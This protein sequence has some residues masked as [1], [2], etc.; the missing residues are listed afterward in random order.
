MKTKAEV[1]ELLKVGKHFCIMPWVH[2]YVSK[3]GYMSPCCQQPV[4]SGALLYGDLSKEQIGD[5]WNGEEIRYL[6]IQM[7]HDKPCDCCKNCYEHEKANVR[8][9]RKLSNSKFADYIDWVLE[10][11]ENGYVESAK[12]VYWDVRFTNKCNLKCRTCSDGWFFGQDLVGMPQKPTGLQN[13]A[14]FLEQLKPYFPTVEELFFSGGEPLLL[15]ENIQI[16]AELDRL[17]KEDTRLIYN[18]NFTKID[19]FLPLWKKF[20]EITFLISIDGTGKRC[21]YLRKGLVWEEIERNMETLKRE[22]PHAHIIADVTVSALN[23]WHLPEMH[24]ELVEKGY[25]QVD[26]FHLNILN[27]PDFYNIRILPEEFKIAVKEKIKEHMKWVKKQEPF[28]NGTDIIHQIQCKYFISKWYACLAY[29]EEEQWQNLISRFIEYNT[30]LDQLR[31]ESCLLVF[32][33]L[34][35]L[36]HSAKSIT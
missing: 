7:L 23:I 1:Y 21:E 9:L 29:M 3:V 13:T 15:D 25:I 5:L 11:D 16:L 28:Y 18:T 31:E 26:E 33:E 19:L 20:K 10:T 35:P 8:S 32:P 36:F 34:E 14:Q 4:V 24:R 2:L 12:P 17:G 22:C 27:E 30:R 6:R